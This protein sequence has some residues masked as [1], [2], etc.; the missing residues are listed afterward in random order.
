MPRTPRAARLPAPDGRALR[1]ERSRTAIVQALLDLVGQGI[2]E[3]TAQQVADRGGVGIRTVFRHFADMETLFAAMDAR[4]Q[5][6]ALPLLLV[7][8]PTGDL[9]DRVRALVE[10]RAAFFERIAPFKR[11]GQLKRWRSPFLTRQ[12]E[13]L[14][15]ELRRGLLRAL[16]ELEHAPAD[17]V[18]AFEQATS[19]EAWDQLRTEQR[20][21]RKRAEAAA[22]RMVHALARDLGA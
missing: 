22:K 10:R 1:S 19:F 21:T 20:L 18:D 12:H 15:R 9:A 4:I 6:D 17:L 13:T 14:R 8:P 16:P 11:S 5:E 2:L 3:P 7:E